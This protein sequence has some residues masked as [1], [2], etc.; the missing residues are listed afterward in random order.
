MNN[1]Y[2]GIEIGGTK[3]Q[4]VVADNHANILERVAD[5]VG[6]EKE[7]IVIQEK[8][9]KSIS[10]LL[11]KYEIKSIGVAFGGPID[12]K[13]GEI[14]TSFHVRGWNNFN[15]K[16]W[17]TKQF[18][19]PVY[20]DNDAN[21]AALAEA[22]LGCGKEYSRVFYITLGSGVG[23]GFIID[24]E[25][26]HGKSLC[27]V[28]FG[29]I[30]L[31]KAGETVEMCCSGWALNKKLHEYI[32]VNP[33][34]ILANL[35][36]LKGTDPSKCILDAINEGDSGAK[37]IF[38]E[39]TDNLA[40]GLSHVIH[41]LNPDIIIIGGG[42]SLIGEIITNS[43]SQNLPKYLM[44]SIKNSLPEIKIAHLKEDVVP[45]GAVFLAMLN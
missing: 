15:I 7:A 4:A 20:V 40:F 18:N 39:M 41:I 12:I 21:T 10:G 13:T 37:H 34:G 16:S 11:L 5:T 27:E 36:K 23:G 3:F 2:L 17:L 19:I 42:L 24:G 25:I 32:T 35:V 6:D 26:Y 14:F 22:R 8:I 33:D 38:F 30:R 28:E 1:K 31:N 43:V 29:H 45:V 9:V 44:S